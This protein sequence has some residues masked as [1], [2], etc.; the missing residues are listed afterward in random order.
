[1]YAFETASAPAAAPGEAGAG[2]S[3]E[4]GSRSLLE[5]EGSG[6]VFLLAMP[7]LV[8]ALPVLARGRRQRLAGWVSTVL[9]G[10]GVLAGIASIGILYLPGVL[11]SA[12]GTALSKTR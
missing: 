9:L 1:M 10:L 4:Q 8:S 2:Y 5:A 6:V 7:V 12:I 11:L 3:Y